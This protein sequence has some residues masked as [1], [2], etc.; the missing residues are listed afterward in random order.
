VRVAQRD[1]RRPAAYAEV[2]ISTKTEK[3]IAK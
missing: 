3:P 2:I 1:R